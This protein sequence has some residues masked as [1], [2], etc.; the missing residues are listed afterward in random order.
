[1]TETE[2]LPV[3]A[4]GEV[5]HGGGAEFNPSDTIMHHI[6]DSNAIEVPFLGE[7]HLPQFA[8]IHLGGLEIDLSPTKHVFF[9]WLAGLF[10]VLLFGLMARRRQ[11]PD[12]APR[13]L[14]SGLEAMILFVRD[15][16]AL[17]NIGPEG[18]RFTPYLLTTFFF[19]LVCNLMG[20]VPGGSTATGNINVTGGLALL[21]FLMIQ[22]GGIRQNG[23]T[24][25]IKNLV[26]HGL[27]LM[28]LPIMIV[29]EV[30]SVFVK[31][32]ALAIRLFANMTGGHVA[33][34][35]LL[36]FAFIM[37]SVVAG[38][39]ALPFALFIYLLEI[40]VAFLQAYIFTMLTSLFIGMTVHPQH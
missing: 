3:G 2:A 29:I 38:V 35:A 30:I 21:A 14:A 6:L 13:G 17:K 24:A 26:P 1:M 34:L 20:L 4:H 19:I 37:K 27:P 7:F 23:L 18:A 15:E 5:P 8:P 39:M 36:C 31:P 32:F 12:K 33:L 9:M 16:L 22:G 40:F 10:L 25:H 28:V 11:G